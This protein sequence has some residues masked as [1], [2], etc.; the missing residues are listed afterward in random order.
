MLLA[1]TL[2]SWDPASRTVTC[3]GCLS[4]AAP[5]VPVDP[6]QAGASAIRHYERLRDAR[7]RRAREKLGPFGGLLAKVTEEPS[8]TR[9]WQ[10]GG[11]G[12]G[13][14]ARRLEKLLDGSGVSLLHDRRVPGHGQRTSI[15]SRLA[16]A[17]LPSLMLRPTAARSVEIGMAGC[18]A[19]DAQSFRSTAVIRPS[20]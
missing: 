19:N 3:L 1:G 10:Q 16:Q 17:A 15:T 14:V 7:E 9:S 8:R 6:G 13:L 4:S 2:A 12:E 11:L 20:W 18:S 5:L